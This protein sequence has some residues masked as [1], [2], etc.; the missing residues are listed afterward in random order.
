MKSKTIVLIGTLPFSSKNF[1]YTDG[2]CEAFKSLLNVVKN[3]GGA[4]LS[5]VDILRISSV[6]K[7]NI[8]FK[9][10]N[11]MHVMFSAIFTILSA[12][13]KSKLYI[14]SAQS[15]RGLMR[16]F[17]FIVC[18]IIKQHEIIMHVH[19][20][21]IGE[22]IKRG[23]KV[24]NFLASIIYNRA[25]LIL[26]LHDFYL[27]M[28]EAINIARDKIIVLPNF[29][30][31]TERSDPEIPYKE[32]KI[33]QLL[34]LSNLIPSKGYLHCLNACEIML[35]QDFLD[36]QI[37]FCGTFLAHQG[38]S[39]EECKMEFLSLI[40]KKG[41]Q[42]HVIYEGNVFGDKKQEIFQEADF[43][44]LP[45]SY[46][47]EGIPI[48]IIEALK[49]QCIVITSDYRALPLMIDNGK[50]GFAIEPTPEKISDCIREV[51]DK[52]NLEDLK[53]KSGIFFEK[54]YS[55]KIAEEKIRNIFS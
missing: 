26:V 51:F 4:E 30:P 45:S 5:V 42:K 9:T 14:T 49:Y 40:Q 44:L 53:V 29:L 25:S 3:I 7:R 47:N 43:F 15:P 13:K 12:S 27:D 17:L 46:P 21:G 52:G 20:G 32:T 34:Y 39:A 48:S 41:L 38:M 28:F 16:D 8:V 10:Y 31:E 2:Q 24:T 50:S 22:T 6:Q 55:A 11:F 19:G 23:S 18:G 1:S 35:Q 36:F 33:I 37:K 54:T